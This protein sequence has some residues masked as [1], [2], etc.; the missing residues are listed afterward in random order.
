MVHAVQ[1]ALQGVHSE[2]DSDSVKLEFFK[3]I[4]KFCIL[5]FVFCFPANR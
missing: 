1:C 3:T 4:I 2:S 5:Y